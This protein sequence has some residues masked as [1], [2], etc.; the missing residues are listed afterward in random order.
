MAVYI[1][2]CFIR[3][4]AERKQNKKCSVTMKKQFYFFRKGFAS[5]FL[6]NGTILEMSV[7]LLNMPLTSAKL[8]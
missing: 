7:A 8:T 5:S 1:K 3:W 6:L 2:C 4:I